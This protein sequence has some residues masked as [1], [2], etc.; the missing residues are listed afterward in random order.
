[1]VSSSLVDD[2]TIELPSLLLSDVCGQFYILSRQHRATA[3]STERKTDN[4]RCECGDISAVSFFSD[5]FLLPRFTRIKSSNNNKSCTKKNSPTSWLYHLLF[6]LLLLWHAQ[7]GVLSAKRRHWSPEWTILSHV[8]CF[9][10]R[11][12]I[13]FQV[14]LDSLHPRSTRAFW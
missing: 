3:V 11:E 2:L 12:V 1:V 6:L 5:C 13:G 14:L 8:N 4:E 7:L 10:Q 9:I